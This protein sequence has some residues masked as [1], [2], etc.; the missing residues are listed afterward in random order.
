MLRPTALFLAAFIITTAFA[1][2]TASADAPAP[3]PAES[4]AANGPV[5][6][7]NA[8][9]LASIQQSL[10]AKQSAVKSLRDKLKKTEDKTEQDELQQK[11]DRIKAEIANLQASFEH[12][13]LGGLNQSVLTEQPELRINWQEELEQISLPV[14]ATLK[15]ITEK[16]RQIDNLRRDLERRESQLKVINKAVDSIRAFDTQ[17]LT[18]AAKKRVSQLLSEWEQRRDETLRA[19]ELTRFKLDSL[20]RDST[21]WRASARES[22][23][24]FAHGRGLTLLLAIVTGIALW[25]VASGLLMLYT[26]WQ[27]KARRKQDE[28]LAPLF[29]YIYR[30]LLAILITFA[31]LMVFYLRGDVLL[32][33]LA[34]IALVG[35][36]LS[37]RQALPRYMAE[38]RL[39]LGVGPVREK[40]RIVL[41]GIPFMVKSL[42]V[43]AVLRNPELDG[44]VRMP[45]HSMDE[46]VSRPISKESWFPCRPEDYIVLGDNRLA[47]VLRQS[48]EYVEVMVLDSIM[49]IRTQDILSQNIRNLTREGFGIACTFGIDYEHQGICLEEVPD[50]FK[51]AV[52][53]RFE[54]EGMKDDVKELMV[55]FGEAG[56]SSL[57]YRIYLIL[58]GSAAKAYY[59]AQRM[60]QQACV[61]TCNREGWIIPFT[62]IT[63]HTGGE[64]QGASGVAETAQ[65][66]A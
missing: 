44:V 16:P 32:L 4:P 52:Q 19:Q 22:L 10:D 33:T 3:A 64:G 27:A 21:D 62:Q 36:V 11:I 51:Q 30:L 40:E 57:D 58:K 18:P 17:A 15:E 47:R 38:V 29:V 43:Y 60:V 42:S 24:E 48:V 50:K 31:V 6:L 7:S 5:Q 37:L 41:D 45:L 23:G 59:K 55:E 8:E 66:T 63:V 2:Y 26:R 35:I 61:D 14:L 25:L 49:Q 13:L 46:H 65:V 56:A 28:M 39:L 34:V 53:A 20:S 1:P 12:I 9:N 54:K